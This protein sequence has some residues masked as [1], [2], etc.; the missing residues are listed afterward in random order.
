MLVILTIRKN[1]LELYEIVDLHKRMF[2]LIH[3]YRA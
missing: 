3:I 2:I 1:F